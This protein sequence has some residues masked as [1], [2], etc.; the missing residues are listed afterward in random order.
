MRRLTRHLLPA[1][2]SCLTLA[3]L[4]EAQRPVPG[5][6]LPGAKLFISPME[7]NLDRAVAAEISRQ[8]L[9]LKVVADRRE[10]DFVMTS[11]YQNLGSRTTSPGHFI[12][13]AIIAADGGRQVW[14][15]E[16]RDFGLFFAQLRSHGRARAAKAIVRKLNNRLSKARS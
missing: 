10:A 15:A 16:V 14:S 5:A 7:W 9:P 6:L 2:V 8:G 4:L 3:G 1:F 13:V 12:Q 11:A